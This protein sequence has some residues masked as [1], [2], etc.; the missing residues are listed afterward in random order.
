M[1]EPSSFQTAIPCQRELAI[2]CPGANSLRDIDGVMSPNDIR[3]MYAVAESQNKSG[4]VGLTS[5]IGSEQGPSGCHPISKFLD[6]PILTP[7]V[8]PTGE[9]I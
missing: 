7:Q 9:E 1:H 4:Y 6:K 8:S 3:V 2:S 5:L